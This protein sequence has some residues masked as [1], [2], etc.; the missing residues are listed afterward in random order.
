M[1]IEWKGNSAKTDLLESALTRGAQD[2]EPRGPCFF[3]GSVASQLGDP[4]FIWPT[5]RG[6]KL[7]IC[8]V[9]RLG[10]L[11]AW[12]ICNYAQSPRN[13]KHA[14]LCQEPET[15][16][17]RTAAEPGN[18]LTTRVGTHIFFHLLKNKAVPYWI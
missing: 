9:N 10:S 8:A 7:I 13:F 15:W 11:E 1:T 17:T 3:S 5:S 14:F 2:K 16:G 18:N 4:F 12:K 6:H